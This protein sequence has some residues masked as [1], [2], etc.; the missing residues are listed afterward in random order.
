MQ[1]IRLKLETY[2]NNYVDMSTAL[3]KL[4]VKVKCFL[5]THTVMQA[6]SSELKTR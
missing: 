5:K 1:S 3:F 2:I 4:P 6:S